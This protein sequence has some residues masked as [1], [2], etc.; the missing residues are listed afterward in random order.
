VDGFDPV[1][2]RLELENIH[3]QIRRDGVLTV[4]GSHMLLDVRRG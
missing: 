2:D 1:D 3:E 4:R